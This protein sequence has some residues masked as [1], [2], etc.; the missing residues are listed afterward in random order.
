M[1]VAIKI[2]VLVKFRPVTL[3]NFTQS[4][5]LGDDLMLNGHVVGNI[6][7]RGT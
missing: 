1:H 4:L 2:G 3:H 6:I 5:W 7:Q